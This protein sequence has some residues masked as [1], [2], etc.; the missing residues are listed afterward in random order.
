MQS[1]AESSAEN[2]RNKMRSQ[3]KWVDYHVGRF[4]EHYKDM[5]G[6]DIERGRP[7]GLEPKYHEALVNLCRSS[8]MH[9]ET[10]PKLP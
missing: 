8:S 6:G 4:A 5:C 10:H 1:I 9:R 3:A 2:R 7:E